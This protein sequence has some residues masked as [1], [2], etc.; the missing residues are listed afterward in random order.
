MRPAADGNHHRTDPP[1]R[2]HPVKRGLT[3]HGLRHSHNTWMIADGIPDVARARRLGHKLPD[4]IQQIYA[5]VAPEIETKLLECLQRRWK[6]ALTGLLQK[7]GGVPGN[8][9]HTQALLRPVV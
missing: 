2:V 3:F 5:H 8:D 4:K 9:P 7:P 6:T 1:V